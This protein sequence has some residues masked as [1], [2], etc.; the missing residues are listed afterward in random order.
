M[1]KGV[2]TDTGA[3]TMH[4]RGDYSIP[5]HENAMH[6]SGGGGGG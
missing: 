6:M 5:G 1:N 3:K 2:T 4:I